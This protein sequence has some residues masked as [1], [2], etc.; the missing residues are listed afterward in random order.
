[1]RRTSADRIASSTRDGASVPWSARRRG[2]VAVHWSSTRTRI[3]GEMTTG[4]SAPTRPARRSRR[5]VASREAPARG[6]EPRDVGLRPEPRPLAFGEGRVAAGVLGD[7]VLAAQGPVEDRPGLAVADRGEGGQA[8]VEA[9]P[10]GARLLD[11]AGVELGSGSGGDPG[12]GGSSG[13]ARARSRRPGRRSRAARAAARCRRRA[14]RS[15]GLGRPGADCAC[16]R[17]P[18]A[19]ERPP[20]AARR[21]GRGRPPGTPPR[22]GHGWPRRRAG[23]RSRSR[24]RRRAGTDPSRRRGSRARRRSAIPPRAPRACAREVGEA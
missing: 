16:R 15:R 19:S 20:A 24:G 23:R 6:V 3:A 10:Q 8:R 14:R 4:V 17:S 5:S 7:R 12:A 21:A 18:P 1:M 9:L 2:G 11:Q 13:R 22:A